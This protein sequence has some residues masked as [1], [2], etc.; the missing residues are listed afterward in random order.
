MERVKYF[1]ANILDSRG[2]Y[3]GVVYTEGPVIAFAGTEDANLPHDR[4]VDLQGMTLMPAFL[5]L[6]CHLRDPGYPFKETLETGMKAALAGGYATLVA[7]AN[8]SPVIETPALVEENH[9]RAKALRLCRLIQAAAAGK[10]LL[11]EAAT[12]WD[13]LSGVTPVLTNDGKNI[14]SDEFMEKLLRFARDRGIV[15]STHAEPEAEITKRDIAIMR[16]LWS[17]NPGGFCPLHVGHISL[18]ETAALIR[19]SKK[20]G[21]P[22]T[23]EI[24]PH[25]LIGWDMDY[26]V[27]PPLRTRAD[28]EALIEAI[29]DGTANILA[30]DHAPHTPEDKAAGMAG[31]SGIEFAFGIYWHV[32]HQNNIP[33]T[34]LSGMASLRPAERLGIKA[35]LIEVGYPADL[36]IV[37]PN[38]TGT[39]VPE[40]MVSRSHNTPFGGYPLRGKVLTTI[41]EGEVRYDH[42]SFVR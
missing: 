10:G 23:S 32:F 38:W 28:A 34:R 21:I 16:K 18:A 8:T 42:G 15:V 41:V 36:V 14:G 3:P 22:V 27:N 40:T 35:G 7:M 26:R 24:T 17:E 20:E 4:T 19:E 30:T 37:D 29:R 2:N 31:I 25:H 9:R 33:L 1:N 13:A 11:D 39:I 6:H 12:D 5:D